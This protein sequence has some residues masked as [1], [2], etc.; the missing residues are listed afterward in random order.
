V[1]AAADLSPRDPG[2][3]YAWHVRTVRGEPADNPRGTRTVRDPGADGPKLAPDHPVPPAPLR[4]A[5][6]VDGVLTDGPPG[7]TRQ[8]GPST[9]DSPYPLFFSAHGTSRYRLE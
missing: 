2:P 6:T 3:T 9:A 8:F 4:P 7:T 1:V 5:R